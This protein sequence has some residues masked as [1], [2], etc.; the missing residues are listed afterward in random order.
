MEATSPVFLHVPAPCGKILFVFF[1]KK[2]TY[3]TNYVV[4]MEIYVEVPNMPLSSDLP[5]SVGCGTR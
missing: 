3:D 2:K 1:F 4:L 5:K